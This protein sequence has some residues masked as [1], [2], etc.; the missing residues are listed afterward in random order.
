M[1]VLCSSLQVKERTQCSV[2]CAV[3]LLL[4]PKHSML[5]L[6]SSLFLPSPALLPLSLCP[7]LSIQ[8][9]TSPKMRGAMFPFDQISAPMSSHCQKNADMHKIFPSLPESEKLIAGVS[10]RCAFPCHFVSFLTS[11]SHSSL[12]RDSVCKSSSLLICCCS[13]LCKYLVIKYTSETHGSGLYLKILSAVGTLLTPRG[14][15]LTRK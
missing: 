15:L 5:S 1:C 12:E 10:P 4:Q 2:A 8:F 9:F 3:L 14:R 11:C 6:I 7:S 13:H